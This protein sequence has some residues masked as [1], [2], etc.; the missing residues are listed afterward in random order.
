MPQDERRAIIESQSKHISTGLKYLPAIARKLYHSRDFGEGIDF[1]TWF[2][3]DPQ[4]VGLF[5]E[6]LSFLRQSIEWK[7]VSREI[8]FRLE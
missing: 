6:L 5:D 2:E 8:E 4:H 7:Y 1:V 3:F